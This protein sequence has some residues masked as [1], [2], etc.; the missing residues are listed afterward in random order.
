M[1]KQ[2]ISPEWVVKTF[3]PDHNK[4]WFRHVEFEGGDLVKDDITVTNAR[5]A[6]FISINFPTALCILLRQQRELCEEMY[7]YYVADKGL[8]YN[9]ELAKEILNAS[10]P[11]NET[12]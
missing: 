4:Q 12:F 9:E 8:P 2:Y 1:N 7:H 10:I 5:Y 3:L 11:D 6:R